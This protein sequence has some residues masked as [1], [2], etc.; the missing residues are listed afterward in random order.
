MKTSA[1]PVHGLAAP[2]PGAVADP[3]T[4]LSAAYGVLIL[5]VATVFA[6]ID[7]QILV[8]LAEPMRASLGLSDTKLGLLQGVAIT[9]FAGLAAVPIGWLADRFGRR[10]LLA[11]SVLVWA[12]AT[13]ACGLAGDF[14]AL[15]LAAIGLGIGEAGLAPIIYGLIPDVVPERRRALANG[16]YALAAILGTGLGLT[17]SGGLMHGLDDLRPLLPAALQGLESWRLAFLAVAAPG[18][19]VALAVLLIRVRR[20]PAVV[21][22]QDA[23]P[24][25]SVRA[26]LNGQSLTALG[27]FGSAGLAALG[28]AAVGNWVPVIAARS[29]GASAAEVGQGI[30]GAYLLGTLAGAAAGAVAV[31]RLRRRLGVATPVRVIALGMGIAALGSGLLL[32][33]DSVLQIYLL[34]GVQVAALI[35]GSVLA[36]TMLQDMTPAPLRSRVIALGTVVSVG[37]SALSPVLVG[38]LSDALQPEPRGLLISVAL[39]C[40]V[41]MGLGAVLM[42]CVEAAFV[43]TV[44]TFHP[45]LNRS[46]S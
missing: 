2:S 23:A 6:A 26:Y 22:G 37:L 12:T 21:P 42:H 9:L 45:E 36:P 27:V 41:A 32:F 40:T 3:R 11:L 30:G 28:L 44:T 29:F 43:R 13:A 34:F 17:L 24:A 33:T 35:A 16:I 25:A 39:V 10:S 31:K 38:L 46:H 5:I 7:R 18:P 14:Q 1:M 15:F 19:L 4:G 8:L 20:T